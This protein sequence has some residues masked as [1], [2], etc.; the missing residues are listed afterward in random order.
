M[1]LNRDNTNSWERISHGSKQ[2]VMNLNNNE[3]EIPEVQLEECALEIG[4]EGFC[5]PI[6]GKSKTTKNRTCWLFT[7]NRSMERRNWIDVE[8]GKHSLSEYEVSKKVI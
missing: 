3:Q 2:F 8:P 7:K 4:C 1:S 6:K 5:L